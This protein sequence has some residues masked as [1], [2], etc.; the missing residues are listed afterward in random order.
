MM[1]VWIVE[2]VSCLV[3]EI[4]LEDVLFH[5]TKQFLKKI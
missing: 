1:L 4:K 3:I 5:N 2:E